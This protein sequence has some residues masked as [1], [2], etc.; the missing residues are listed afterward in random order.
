MRQRDRGLLIVHMEKSK[1]SLRHHGVEGP[2]RT[3]RHPLTAFL[4]SMELVTC[5][6]VLAV[7][8]KLPGIT[9]GIKFLR[10]VPSEGCSSLY[11][12]INAFL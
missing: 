6:P 3:A 9:F 11:P 7:A 12:M 4:D 2:V 5:C 10:M 8:C 1:F